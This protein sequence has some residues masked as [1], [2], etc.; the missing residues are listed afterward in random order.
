M[1]NLCGQLVSVIIRKRVEEE[2][3]RLSTVVEQMAETVVI[4]DTKGTMQYANPAFEVIS[5]YN[6]EEALNKNM[7]ILKSGVHENKFYKELWD[8]IS[9]GRVWNGKIVN[10]RKDG[11]LYE[12]RAT[13][14]PLT[15][16]EGKIVNF[17]AVKEDITRE[18]QLEDQLMQSQKL[19]TVGTLA[20]GIAHDFNNILA[21]ILGYNEMAI[22]DSAPN[23]KVHK[24]LNRMKTASLRARDLVSQ[25]LTFSRDF[26]TEPKLVKIKDVIKDSLTLFHPNVADNIKT[27]TQIDKATPAIFADPLQLQQVILNLLTN[28]NQAMED[29]GGTIIIGTD[30]FTTDESFLERNTDLV[31]GDYVR[32]SVT[33]TG[34]GM[35]ADTQQKIFEP[36]FSTK[37]VG[38]GTGLGL[39]VVHGI[40]KNHKGVINFESEEGK[41][42][43]F[44]VY[45][46]V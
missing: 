39:S 10:R 18:S 46:P 6:R 19:E 8:T 36:F 32:I 30:K 23:E 35:D 33:D 20:R 16:E 38:V 13:I 14:S 25:I 24:Y 28:A 15:N 42:T 45:L 3:I 11:S 22:E 41:G 12:E 4:T 34:P 26:K 37:P 31:P 21:T 9:K 2:R 44:N 27:K 5:G 43:T 29:S 7:N 40:I 17:V 1:S